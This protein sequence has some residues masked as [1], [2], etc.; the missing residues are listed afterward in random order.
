MSSIEYLLE[1]Y[2]ATVFLT[3]ECIVCQTKPNLGDMRPLLMDI[4]ERDR[5]IFPA[6]RVAA[7]ICV[8]C[9]SIGEGMDYTTFFT[10][11]LDLVEEY[12]YIFCY[13][14]SEGKTQMV[15]YGE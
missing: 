15:K 2:I 13:K 6:E 1:E 11:L 7:C 10:L 12:P 4:P 14:D 3:D 5:D 9:A 8:K